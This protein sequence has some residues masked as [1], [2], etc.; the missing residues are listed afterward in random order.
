MIRQSIPFIRFSQQKAVM[1]NVTAV[2]DILSIIA[3]ICLICMCRHKSEW[4]VVTLLKGLIEPNFKN[5]Y[6][7]TWL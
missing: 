6:L 4:G 3:L 7:L 2:E 1:L 5:S